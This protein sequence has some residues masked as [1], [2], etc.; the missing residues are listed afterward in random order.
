MNTL[1]L[2]AAVLAVLILGFLAFVASKPNVFRVSRSRLVKAKPEAIFPLIDD[3]KA[4]TQ[5]SPY[6]GRDPNM[7]RTYGAISQG[8]GAVYE[9]SGD[10][11]T[12]GSGR[13]EIL[14]R[15]VASK[16]VIKLDFFT[17]FEGHNTGEFTMEAQGDGTLVTW[18]MYGPAPFMSKLMGTLFDMDKMIGKDFEIGLANLAKLTEG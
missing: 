14:D 10:K 6:E 8:Q 16:V 1:T 7:A 11:K 15:T 18:S 13:M 5:W 4:W 3:F 9:W 2:I 12:I 17:P